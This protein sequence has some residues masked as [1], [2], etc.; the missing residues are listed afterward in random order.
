MA[1]SEV[2]ERV[3][4]ALG[5]SAPLKTAPVPP[6]IEEPITRLVH[7]EI[8]LPELWARTAELNKI[9]VETVYVDALAEKLIEFLKSKNVK[10]VMMPVSA[11]LE[12]VGVRPALQ[13]A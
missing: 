7:S 4:R 5:R 2:I 9:H 8:G 11:L 13:S 10:R 12:K 3:R 1:E 6:V